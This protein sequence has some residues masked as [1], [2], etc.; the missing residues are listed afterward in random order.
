MAIK[1]IGKSI[2]GIKGFSQIPSKTDYC[3]FARQLINISSSLPKGLKLVMTSMTGSNEVKLT[4]SAY[5]PKIRKY[6]P[7]L[8]D[9]FDP[10]KIYD[11]CVKGFDNLRPGSDFI[12]WDSNNDDIV[13]TTF[14]R[15]AP[16]FAFESSTGKK[17]LGVIL[18][19][20][21][22]QYGDYLFST[23]KDYLDGEITVTLV[24]CNHYEYPDGS[25][26]SIVQNL[27]L[28]Y[29]INCAI[30]VDSEKDIDC[31]HRGEEGNHVVAVW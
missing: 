17:A 7:E 3:L 30:G 24:T 6:S 19:P 25:I 10:H 20:S 14:S 28:K 15:E 21:L 26:P 9:M 27:S 16:I 8:K 31:Y 1:L 12:L 13:V 18:R 2:L 23:I 22:M 4:N 5:F 29:N 11:Y